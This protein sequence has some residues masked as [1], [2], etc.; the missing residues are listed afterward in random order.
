MIAS[1]I[2]FW[3]NFCTFCE[4]KPQIFSARACGVRVNFF[5]GGRRSQKHAFVSASQCEALKVIA[6]EISFQLNFCIFRERK[7]QIFSARACSARMNCFLCWKAC[8]KTCVRQCLAMRGFKP[9]GDFLAEIS[10]ISRG[11]TPSFRRLRLRRSRELFYFVLECTH[12]NM[13]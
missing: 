8:R 2:S 1:K 5:C 7:P 4:V 10:H 11:E 6:S 3:L 13:R 9:V 12:K